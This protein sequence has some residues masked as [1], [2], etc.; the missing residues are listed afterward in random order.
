MPAR[1]RSATPLSS[2]P[3]PTGPRSCSRACGSNA[4]VA[5]AAA[6]AL[7][8]AR[9]RDHR[10]SQLPLGAA[11]LLFRAGDA[12][13]RRGVPHPRQR[14][15]FTGGAAG[16]LLKLDAR[17]RISSSRAARSS[18]GSRSASS[19]IALLATRAIERSRFGAYLVAIREN[20][21]AASGARRRHA[22]GEG[23]GDHAFGGDRGGGGRASTPNISCS[24]TPTSPS[25]P[26]FRSRR[27]W[28]RSS[29][30]WEPRW[31][32]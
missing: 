13:L 24:S 7:G 17:P 16:T 10:L 14:L 29:A 8:A 1:S 9:R 26:G 32:R 27:C 3:A 6:I 22:E 23:A 19:A 4:Y 28:R 5:F 20:E 18:S 15:A 2:A 31:A 21:E 11:R 25:E 12:R 30:D